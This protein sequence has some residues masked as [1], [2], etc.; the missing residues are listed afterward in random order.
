MPYTITSKNGHN[1]KVNKKGRRQKKEKH[2]KLA[3]QKKIKNREIK[4]RK[5]NQNENSKTTKFI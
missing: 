5:M 4:T 2:F 1:F 3:E